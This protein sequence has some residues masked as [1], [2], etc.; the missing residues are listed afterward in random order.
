MEVRAPRRPGPLARV[1]LLLVDDDDDIR[2]CVAEILGFHGA[3]VTRARSGN[4]GFDIFLRQRPDVVLSDLWMLDG[5]GFEMIRR[6]RAR[7][8][9]EG[10]LTPALAF[11]AAEH[12]RSAMTAGFHAFI[13]KPFDI[14]RLLATVGDFTR[15]DG[16]SR[17]ATPWT[18]QAACPNRVIV[19]LYDDVRATDIAN[20]MNA[21]FHHLDGGPVDVIVDLSD[22]AS[23]A[24]SVGSVGERALWS[25]REAI[26][27]LRIVG[28][29]ALARLIS[30]S[31]C[32]ILRIPCVES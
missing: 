21:L 6:I 10:G 25:R 32:R 29:S 22:L 20:L 14:S 30:T 28:G 18:I 27:S 11:S 7:D 13:A 2:D 4:E 19:K 26:R 1:R 31:A 5:D 17:F 24:P 23:F 3:A 12:L 15:I 8:P 9:D 16:G